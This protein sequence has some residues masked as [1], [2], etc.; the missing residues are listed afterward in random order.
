MEEML[1]LWLA[2][3][4]LASV[5]L[6]FPL[7]AMAAGLDG[8]WHGTIQN[9]ANDPK[10]DR[11]LF[12]EPDG[13]CKFDYPKVTKKR[14]PDSVRCTIDRAAG[15]VYLVT[16]GNSKVSLTLDGADQLKGVF[17]YKMGTYEI[18]YQITLRRGRAP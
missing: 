11:E 12:I 4:A 6:G 14:G 17:M 3:M 18:P 16:S 5:S 9:L 2:S 1:R 10:P 8:P 15:K 7:V 13:T